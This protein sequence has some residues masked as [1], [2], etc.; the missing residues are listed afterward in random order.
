[1][2]GPPGLE[3]GTIWSGHLNADF[4]FARIAVPKCLRNSR[5]VDAKNQKQG[6]GEVARS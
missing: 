2:V 5:K 1:M 4:L 3:P 6:A